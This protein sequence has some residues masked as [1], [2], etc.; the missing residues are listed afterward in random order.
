[1]IARAEADNRGVAVLP[2]SET[3]RD[4]SLQVAGAA[5][6]QIKQ[7]KPKP[8]A[9]ERTE[10]LSGI[11]RFLVTAPNVEIVW[12]SDGV[13]LGKGA[14]FVEGLK[15]IAGNHPLTVVEGGLPISHALTAADNA[16]GALTVK[17][18]RAQ[19]APSDGGIVNAIDLKG[20]PLGE[21]PF[22]FKSGEREA[23]AVIDLPVEIRNDVAE[24]RDCRR[25]LGRRGAAARQ[26]LA[27]TNNWCRVRIDCRPFAAP[28]RCDLLSLSRA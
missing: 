20:L 8:Y 12:L 19:T 4:I 25:T 9:V 14:I 6:V 17:V 27:Q 21:A 28:D 23:D 22:N 7:I 18:L 11:E 15:R 2:I 24:L 1:M 3:E 13:D 10:A 16:A 26:A 5:R